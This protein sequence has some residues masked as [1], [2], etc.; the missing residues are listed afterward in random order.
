MSSYKVISYF[1]SEIKKN[2][3]YIEIQFT[4]K[5]ILTNQK[6]KSNIQI[7]IITQKTNLAKIKTLNISLQNILISK[8]KKKL[9]QIVS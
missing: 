3:K 1:K 2:Y 5:Y 7:Q 4:S 6:I 8:Q 9:N